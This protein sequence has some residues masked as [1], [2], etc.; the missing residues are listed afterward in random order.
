MKKFLIILFAIIILFAGGF[1]YT[2]FFKEDKEPEK[3]DIL[4]GRIV[5]G[6]EVR[7][8]QLCGKDQGSIESEWIDGK[9]SAYEEIKKA[10]EKE[11][12]GTGPF[13]PM[14]AEIAGKES[15][16]LQDG[17]GANYNKAISIEK[18]VSYSSIGSCKNDFI[19]LENVRPG[20]YIDPGKPLGLIG[21]ARGNWYFEASFPIEILDRHANILAS[22]YATAQGEWMTTE[23]VPFKAEIKFTKIPADNSFGK[24]VLKK[25]NPSDM[26]EL[27]D[28]L[29]V[30]VYFGSK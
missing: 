20:D 17:F 18:L 1:V 14:Y 2:K 27:D 21:K 6:D 4:K 10:Y 26:R 9:S 16:K 5:W 11:M 23:F 19:V 7:T 30:L 12:V 15:P 29:E 13:A 25:D 28:A 22:G 3:A 24:I 8:F